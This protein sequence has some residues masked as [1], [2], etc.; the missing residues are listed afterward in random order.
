MFVCIGIYVW[1]LQSVL[2][3]YECPAWTILILLPLTY[4]LTSDKA[5]LP[6]P[7]LVLFIYINI[8]FLLFLIGYILIGAFSI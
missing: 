4:D 6:L 8:F 5:N 3:I 7:S 2:A 1:S